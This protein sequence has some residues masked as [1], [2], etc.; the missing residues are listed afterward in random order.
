VYST[1]TEIVHVFLSV[2]FWIFLALVGLA[3]WACRRPSGSRPRRWRAWFIAA[4]VLF[5]IVS[6]PVLP[7]SLE[8]WLESRFPRRA[9]TAADRDQDNVILVLTAGYL[10]TTADGF[11]QKLGEAGWERTIAAVHL[12]RTIGGRVMFTGAPTPDGKDSAAAAMGRVA[13]ELGLPADAIMVE[14]AS[15]NTVENFQYSKRMLGPGRHRIWLITSAL[16]MPRSVAAAR[17][18]GIEVLPFPVDYRADERWG[19]T[20]CLPS[21]STRPAMEKTMHELLGMLAYRLKGAG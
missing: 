3:I 10:R 17:M 7:T 18:N 5:Y 12:W 13:A 15:L 9:A 6:V 21:N 8:R 2:P 19:W 20:D 11:D 14:P 1:A 4:P 16:H